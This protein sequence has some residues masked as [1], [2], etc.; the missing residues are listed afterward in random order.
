M[1]FN[2]K[3]HFS[4]SFISTK[5][6]LLLLRVTKKLWKITVPPYI[7]FVLLFF[8]HLFTYITRTGK[9]SCL[10]SHYGESGLKMVITVNSFS[11]DKT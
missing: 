11:C 6:D 2:W 10:T 7:I 1:P 4:G 5:H 3:I 8:A 9:C